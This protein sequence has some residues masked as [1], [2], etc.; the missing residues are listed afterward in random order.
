MSGNSKKSYYRC[1]NCDHTVDSIGSIK[2]HLIIKNG[3]G[4]KE[5]AI[6]RGCYKWLGPSNNVSNE[7]K[8][9]NEEIFAKGAEE[10]IVKL[11]SIEYDKEG[12]FIKNVP[13]FKKPISIDNSINIGNTIGNS[14]I[15]DQ[16]NTVNSPFANSTIMNFFNDA[17]KSKSQCQLPYVFDKAPD[18]V[19][20]PKCVI[21]KVF[22][23]DVN[24]LVSLIGFFHCNQDNTKYHNMFYLSDDEFEIYTKRGIIKINTNKV[25]S[26]I[27]ILYTDVLCT[28]YHYTNNKNTITN[29]EKLFD[30]LNNDLEYLEETLDAIF[31]MFKKVKNNHNT[32]RQIIENAYVNDKNLKNLSE[33]K[34]QMNLKKFQE[35]KLK[36]T[37]KEK[38]KLNSDESSS[39]E[40]IKLKK[41]IKKCESS[42]SSSCE[43]IKPK[44][45]DKKF[46]N[47]HSS[48][49]E[50]IK[51]KNTKRKK[52]NNDKKKS[53]PKGDL[54]NKKN[55]IN[56]TLLIK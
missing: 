33:E 9:S 51:R 42:D 18:L 21:D 5:N 37:N 3:Y 4:C 50:N 16:K 2:T 31:N 55:E 13:D 7:K 54:N 20:F 45:I 38:S 8:L 28:V 24:P 15:I 11:S 48:S 23:D 40:E 26:K 6:K 47:T 44:K 30:N 43:V 36:K 14:N 52:I 10:Y 35:Q 19:N 17:D 25:I 41:T 56:I 39:F 12:D 34:V 29:L 1:I 49:S 53:K 32:T 46:K 22:R 27:I